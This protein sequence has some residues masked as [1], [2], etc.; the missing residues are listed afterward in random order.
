M[1]DSDLNEIRQ[2]THRTALDLALEYQ[3]TGDENIF[4]VLLAKYDELLLRTMY[5]YKR[6]N[7][8]MCRDPLQES[9]H[10]AII[11]FSNCIKSVPSTV[12]PNMMP[13]R[14]IRY[15]EAAF[16]SA[17]KS[18][19]NDYEFV[20]SQ[21][22]VS[23]SGKSVNKD[24]SITCEVKHVQNSIDIE[25]L[26]K[27]AKLNDREKDMMRMRDIDELSLNEICLN[28]RGMP[29]STVRRTINVA[30]KKLKEIV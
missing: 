8:F 18:Q 26:F 15:I 28:F 19:V 2:M 4:A 14:I 25:Y 3:S 9:Y 17:Y 12:N 10:I 11:G 22:L 30:M 5:N 21:Y 7:K 13:A 20:R 1:R 23:N 24:K 27:R 6:A 16:R 29:I